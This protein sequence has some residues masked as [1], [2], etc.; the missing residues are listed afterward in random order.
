MSTA[1]L[2]PRVVHT[3]KLVLQATSDLLA[4]HGFERLTIEAIAEKTGVARSTIYRNWPNREDLYGQAFDLVCNFSEIPDLGSLVEELTLLATELAAGLS[5]EAWGA[6]LP[7]L[8]SA[9]AHDDTL[10]NAHRA[11]ADRRRFLVSEV[12]RRAAARGEISSTFPPETLAM[13]FAAGFFFQNLMVR[14]PIDAAFIERQIEV[15]LALANAE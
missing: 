4:E 13:T 10:T 8:L 11:F 3:R 6:A 9:A 5:D 1:E 2:D 7:S 15:V 12:F 14:L